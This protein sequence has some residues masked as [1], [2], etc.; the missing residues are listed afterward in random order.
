MQNTVLAAMLSLAFLGTG[1]LNTDPVEPEIIVDPIFQ[2]RVSS[3]TITA[4]EHL[5]IRIAAGAED[6]YAVLQN[7][8]GTIGH[9]VQVVSNIFT[10]V[11][12]LDNRIHLYQSILLD[13]QTGT[14][15]G[16]QIAFEEGKVKSIY[17]N[18]GSKLTQWP[19]KENASTSVRVGDQASALYDKLVNINKKSSYANKF[20]RISLFTKELASQYDPI[21]TQSPQW[22]FRYTVE[23][24]LYE[25]VDVK[26]ESG[27]VKY[28]VVSRYQD[29]I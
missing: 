29:T 22:Y 24:K 25:H 6:V 20:E 16:V 11:N 4:G 14:D 8:Q 5:G 9:Y 18:S 3:D 13:E 21:M 7:N 2:I 15:S 27:K 26:M 1:C 12:Q 10:N 17:L 19:L 23:P 28:L